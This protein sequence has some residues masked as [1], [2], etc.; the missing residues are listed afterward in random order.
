MNPQ[1]AVTLAAAVIAR[2]DDRLIALLQSRSI[3]VTGIAN[4][5]D[6]AER[7]LDPTSITLALGARTRSEIA[8]LA[9][10]T[11]TPDLDELALGHEGVAFTAVQ[12]AASTAKLRPDTSAATPT[13]PTLSDDASAVEAAYRSIVT[14]GELVAGLLTRGIE[15]LTKGG[16]QA[17]ELRRMAELLDVSVDE[18]KIALAVIRTAKLAVA[19][20][21]RLYA[22]AEGEAWLREPLAV[23]WNTIA[24]AWINSL[25]AH[26]R[27]VVALGP[28]SSIAL[29][30]HFPLDK[31]VTRAAA[32]EAAQC[33]LFLGI[34]AHDGLSVIG[35][36]ALGGDATETLDALVPDE[37]EHFY[38]QPDLTIV[39]PGPLAPHVL[40]QLRLLA[41][42]DQRGLAATFRMNA[43]SITRALLHKRSES[44]LREFLQ[45]RSLTGVPQ[46]VDY[47]LR[48][49]S[50][51]F[52]TLRVRALD[53]ASVG[54]SGRTQI[55]SADESLLTQLSVDRALGALGLRVAGPS[56][57]VARAE[58]D[59]VLAALLD[60]RYPAAKETSEGEIEHRELLLA[61]ASEPLQPYA[62]LITRLRGGTEDAFEAGGE[63]AWMERQLLAAVR[64][65]AAITVYVDIG[66]NEQPFTLIPTG[67]AG[68]RL[69]AKDARNDVERTL[70]VSK[71]LRLAAADNLGR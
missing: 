21:R 10:G 59:T 61:E 70:P 13:S 23:R 55:T 71:I 30:S 9:S 4:A 20:E 16:V 34:H 24:V 41:D 27:E 1:E 36:A 52:G 26:I 51:R 56:K 14:T 44:D 62:E 68:G 39:A 50:R 2:S 53:T 35:R 37:I 42:L 54:N 64:D 46:P 57:V 32:T 3:P 19:D 29:T 40:E 65:R 31:G 66:G 6:I 60:Q 12:S 58:P 7:L 5:F 69:R 25:P 67:L 11:T 8:L 22:T 15:L 49:T 28:L 33:A 18:I 47:L 17:S 38:V 43:A 48:E 45:A 63:R